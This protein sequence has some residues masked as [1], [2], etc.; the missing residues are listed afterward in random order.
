MS[1][2]KWASA[3]C[4]WRRWIEASEARW[5]AS[6]LASPRLVCIVWSDS[7]WMW[8]AS[9]VYWFPLVVCASFPCPSRAVST[10]PFSL[11][12]WVVVRTRFVSMLSVPCATS[13][14]SDDSDFPRLACSSKTTRNSRLFCWPNLVLNSE[15]SVGNC[16]WWLLFAWDFRFDENHQVSVGWTMLI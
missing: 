6:R 4:A 12:L 7:I 5:A 11:S 2:W 14:V 9:E 1:S 16:W 13:P 15:L 3:V 8:A 10:R